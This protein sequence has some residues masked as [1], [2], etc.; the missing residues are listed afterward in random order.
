M[1]K[2]A[3]VLLS[4]ASASPV[5]AR[6]ESQSV[7]QPPVMA[8]ASALLKPGA[9]R[10]RWATPSGEFVGALSG[11]Q[12]EALEAATYHGKVPSTV[13]LRLS[14][15]QKLEVARLHRAGWKGGII[16][17]AIGAALGSALEA[18][19]KRI[20][21]AIIGAAVAGEL[22]WRFPVHVWRQIDLPRG[23]VAE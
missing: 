20:R 19:R 4:V 8:T 3:V 11:V 7:C 13:V 1:V 15:L 12:C 10:I 23:A 9:V 14:D 21:G 2:I 16:A 5:F 22:G 17:A 18:D 6:E